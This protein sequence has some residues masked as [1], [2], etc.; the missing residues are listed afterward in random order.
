M[1]GNLE[2]STVVGCKMRCSYCP[3]ASHIEKYA[4][5]VG[6]QTPLFKMTL[7][8]FMYFIESVPKEVDIVFAGMAEPFLNPDA[9]GMIKYAYNKGHIISVYTTGQ[10]LKLEDIEILKQF[11]YNH[12][13][14]HLPDGDGDM[15][16]I[17]D[18]H[19]LNV[20]KELKGLFKNTMCIGKIHPKVKETLGF[21]VPDSTSALFSRAGALKEL[22]IP[23]KNGKIYCSVCTD[24]L[25][26][27]VLM[28]NG[29]VLLCCMDYDQ[30]H[31]IG[32]LKEIKYNQ[33]FQTEEYK[34]VL[35]GLN[36]E[37]ID[38]LCRTCEISKNI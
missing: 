12:F 22:M 20:I 26:H 27:N 25:N 5:R 13:C 23:R 8:D 15:N 35:N 31:I 18:E 11:Q 37:S 32:N 38:I 19:Y 4:E 33:I 16:L 21:D 24:S 9:V 36:D 29:D 14:L 30:K 1:M 28:P 2:I 7:F 10:G 34:K 6:K 3:Q 17:V